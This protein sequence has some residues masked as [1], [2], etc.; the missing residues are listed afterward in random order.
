M[1]KILM[2]SRLRKMGSASH[3]IT[4]EEIQRSSKI[5][6]AVFSRY[7]D[8]IASF[9][10][11][12]EFVL[13]Y[14]DK[15]FF[16]LTSPQLSP[17]AEAIITGNVDLSY[18]NRRRNPLKLLRII[19]KLKRE[20]IDLGLNPFSFGMDSEFFITFAKAFSFFNEFSRRPVLYN[21]YDRVREYLLMPA[22]DTSPRPPTFDKV[23]SIVLAPSSTEIRKSLDR[24][25]LA[26]LIRQLKNRFSNPDITVALPARDWKNVHGVK[27]FKLSKTIKKS[28]EFLSLVKS[29]DVF[30]GV[31]AG[32]LHLADALGVRAIGIFGPNAPETFMDRDSGILPIRY[33]GLA[34]IYCLLHGCK[35]PV[36]IHKLF[37]TSFLGNNTIIKFGRDFV[38]ERNVCRA[39]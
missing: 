14:P 4:R 10:V 16:I 27:K 35:D 37:D 34:G 33:E 5:L 38:H 2:N 12:S 30:V 9:K 36:C 32:P 23:R 28:E 13:L 21:L 18:V 8:A 19:Q 15:A 26:N 20:K 39:C 29:A 3:Q 24:N 7:G 22:K 17:Y 25:D 6:F 11:I 31:D 1:L